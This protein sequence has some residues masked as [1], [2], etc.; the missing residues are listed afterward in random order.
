MCCVEKQGETETKDSEELIGRRIAHYTVLLEYF[1]HVRLERDKLLITLSSAGIGL[2]VTLLSFHQLISSLAFYLVAFSF[3][4]FALCI[5]AL[6]E[7]FK[8]NSFFLSSEIKGTT[9][10]ITTDRMKRLDRFSKY[11][12]I[13]GAILL[14]LYVV[15]VVLEKR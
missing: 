1:I 14:F 2:L 10:Q 5:W 3:L 13:L 6:L 9:E 8:L 11:S 4:S 15:V 12:F 7:I